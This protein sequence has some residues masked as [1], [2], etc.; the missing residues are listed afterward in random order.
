MGEKS[1]P[2]V[3][4]FSGLLDVAIVAPTGQNS[5]G[6]NFLNSDGRRNALLPLMY[7]MHSR[8]QASSHLSVYDIPLKASCRLSSRQTLDYPKQWGL[9]V[10]CSKVRHPSVTKRFD[11][12]QVAAG[13]LGLW[14]SKAARRWR[15]S[16]AK[17]AV[18][19]LSIARFGHVFCPTRNN[20]QNRV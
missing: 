11:C 7:T 4:L 20:Q 6:I 9:C 2:L 19:L 18:Y 12:C 3:C 17:A 16:A 1:T 15:S 5:C 8:R 14:C 13:P 10:P